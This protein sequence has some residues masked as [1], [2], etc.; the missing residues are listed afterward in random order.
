MAASSL[1]IN[2][3]MVTFL[4]HAARGFSLIV[5]SI[6]ETGAGSVAVSAA[7]ALPK[8]DSTSGICRMARSVI[9]RILAA[10]PSDTPGKVVGI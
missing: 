1:S 8:T 7:P 3:S 9:C 2:P 5:V 10:S 6:I 4:G